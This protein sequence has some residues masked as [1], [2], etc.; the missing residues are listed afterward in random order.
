MLAWVPYAFRPLVTRPKEV[1]LDEILNWVIVLTFD[2][3]I[4]YFF[5]IQAAV[6]LALSTILGLGCHPMSGHFVAEHFETISGQET[7]SYY[8]CLNYLGY[9]VGY[10]NEHHDFPRVPG[11]LLP[12]VKEIAPEYYDMP[13]YN[14]WCRVLFDFI[15][16]DNLTCFAR[17]KRGP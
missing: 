11:R 3:A 7:Y 9:N 2:A 17:V 4:T 5:G 15:M 1:I 8:G 13:S 12:K 16:T 14:S 6:Y 10:H